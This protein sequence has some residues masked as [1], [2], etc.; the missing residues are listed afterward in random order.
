MATAGP[1]SDRFPFG[2]V[3]H[4]ATAIDDAFGRWDRSHLHEFTLADS[5]VITPHRWWDGEEPDGSPDGATAR[6][7]RLR[8]TAW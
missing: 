4:F 1:G 7:G 6:P 2:D 8:L 3:E 5:T